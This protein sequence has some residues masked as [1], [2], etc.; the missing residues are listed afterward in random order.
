MT[1]GG[2]RV[3]NKTELIFGPPQLLQ[4]RQFLNRPCNS[5]LLPDNV[6][7]TQPQAGGAIRLY[8]TLNWSIL[9]PLF[10]IVLWLN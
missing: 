7:C 3:P 4:V 8:S 9:S 1:E 6:S 10:A 5:V 2:I